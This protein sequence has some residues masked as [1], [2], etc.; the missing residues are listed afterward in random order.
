M[1][2]PAALCRPA[3]HAPQQPNNR[4]VLQ[5]PSNRE[6]RRLT[7]NR[8][9]AVRFPFQHGIASIIYKILDYLKTLYYDIAE[10][11]PAEW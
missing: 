7:A 6:S 10:I 3:M 8:R 11:T 4:T 5:N 2:F 1:F 9:P